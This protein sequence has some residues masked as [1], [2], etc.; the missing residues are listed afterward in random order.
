MATDGSRSPLVV[1]VGTCRTLQ[2]MPLSSDTATACRAASSAWNGALPPQPR[3]GT[4][5]VP[6]GAILMWPWMPAQSA[7]VYI[8]TAGTN[9]MP[10]SRLIEQTASATDCEEYQTLFG[11]EGLRPVGTGA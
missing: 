8:G 9:V 1:A 2:V 3:F 6:S 7:A 5:A 10:P 11:Y 4:Y